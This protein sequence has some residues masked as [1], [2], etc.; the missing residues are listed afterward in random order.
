MSFFLGC[1]LFAILEGAFVAGVHFREKGAPQE[2]KTFKLILYSLA[3][4]CCWMMWAIMY[5]AQMT[6][7]IRPI[8]I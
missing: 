4:F 8:L 3:V 7:L 5:C 6:P 1:L 2:E